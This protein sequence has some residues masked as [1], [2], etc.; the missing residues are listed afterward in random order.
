VA[1]GFGVI[2][3]GGVGV[4]GLRAPETRSQQHVRVY[5]M[6]PGLAGD[7]RAHMVLPDAEPLGQHLLGDAGLI[8]R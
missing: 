5:E 4:I 7:D 1:D 8:E 6:E 3:L 2:E